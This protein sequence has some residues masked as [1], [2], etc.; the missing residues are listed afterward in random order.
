M[1]SRQGQR[2]TEVAGRGRCLPDNM[3]GG[4]HQTPCVTL[5]FKLPRDRMGSRGESQPTPQLLAAERQLPHKLVTNSFFLTYNFE[6]LLPI[7]SYH[8]NTG[9]ISYTVHYIFKLILHPTLF[10]SHSLPLYPPDPHRW[11][12]LVSSLY[13]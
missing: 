11:Y 5:P 9:C 6:K 3:A 7:Y 12:P 8:K 13:L 1:L 10:T 4:R 2:Q